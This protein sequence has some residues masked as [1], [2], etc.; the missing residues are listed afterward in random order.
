[1]YHGNNRDKAHL[2]TSSERVFTAVGAPSRPANKA[3]WTIYEM[4]LG[5]PG[6]SSARSFG[7]PGP[8]G[9]TPLVTTIGVVAGSVSKKPAKT[10]ATNQA[11]LLVFMS[12]SPLPLE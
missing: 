2:V 8:S 5:M 10:T 11:R 9:A 1:M 12:V 4:I 6:P 7:M 3:L